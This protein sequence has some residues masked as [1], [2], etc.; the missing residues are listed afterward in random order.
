[1]E[2]LV[3]VVFSYL[4]TVTFGV[5]TN[6]PRKALNACGITGAAGW[7]IFILL[8]QME[9]GEV[10]A[11]FF[12][13][14]CIGLLSIYFSRKKKMPTILFNIPSIV[15]LVPGGP[16]YQAIRNFVLDNYISGFHFTMTV[17]MT[18]AS[19]AAGFMVTSLVERLL[20]RYAMRKNLNA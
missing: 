14:V 7:M 8:R 6:I 12:S 20:K 5:I 16:A 1:M 15:P 4:S 10:F 18:A 9:A 3:N 2:L 11:N 17:V 13:A 19:I